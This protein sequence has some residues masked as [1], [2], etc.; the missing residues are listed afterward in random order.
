MVEPVDQVR[1]S[2][3]EDR[4]KVADEDVVLVLFLVANQCSVE[5][6]PIA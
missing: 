4:V 2:L 6:L 3:V 1:M 5:K